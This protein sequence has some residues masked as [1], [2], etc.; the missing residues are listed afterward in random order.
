M[1]TGV[2]ALRVD[3]RSSE[4][5]PVPVCFG[6]GAATQRV[7]EVLDRWPGEGYCYFRVRTLEGALYILRHDELDDSWQISVY[8]RGDPPP[9]ET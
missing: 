3:C 2:R 6:R 1:A 5:G 9:G 7:A 8:R 4:A